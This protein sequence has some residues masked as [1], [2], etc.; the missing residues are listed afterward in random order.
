MEPFKLRCGHYANDLN[1]HCYDQ[2]EC[3]H[4][5][6]CDDCDKNIMRLSKG[7]LIR[8][9]CSKCIY[10]TDHLVVFYNE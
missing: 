3:F 4:Y 2:D 6:D 5:S 10:E 7:N 9:G 1:C 8:K